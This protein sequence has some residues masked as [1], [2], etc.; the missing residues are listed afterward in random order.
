M[1]PIS[2]SFVDNIWAIMIV[3]SIRGKIVRTVLCCIVSSYCTV[4]CTH[5]SAVLTVKCWFRCAFCMF[6]CLFYFITILFL[7]C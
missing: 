3:W 6:F 2:S 5:L 7:H 4:M 1:Y